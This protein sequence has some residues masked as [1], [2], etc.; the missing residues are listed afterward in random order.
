M[1][2]GLG[3]LLRVVRRRLRLNRFMAWLA[4]GLLISGGMVLSYALASRLMVLPDLDLVVALLGAVVVVGTTVALTAGPIEPVDAALVA[5][6]WLDSGD[7]FASALTLPTDPD[8]DP[9]GFASLHAARAE[10]L[11]G[12]VH[13]LPD[14]PDVPVRRLAMGASVVALAAALLIVPNPRDDDRARLAADEALA[15]EA[16]ALLE[17]AAEELDDDPAPAAP[18]LAEQLRELA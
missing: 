17:E 5:D 9:A 7:A 18:A 11:A 12:S 4:L 16:A 3:R 6:R 15:E 14:G 10:R 8:A 13:G 1:G 2:E